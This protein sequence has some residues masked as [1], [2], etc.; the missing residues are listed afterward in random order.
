MLTEYAPY[1]SLALVLFYFHA[2]AEMDF[3][4]FIA[5]AFVYTLYGKVL[6]ADVV[7]YRAQIIADF[8]SF[9]GFKR[10]ASLDIVPEIEPGFR[11]LPCLSLNFL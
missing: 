3:P 7:G 2:I 4:V 11:V 8:K 10:K 6:V 5:Q 1:I 9:A